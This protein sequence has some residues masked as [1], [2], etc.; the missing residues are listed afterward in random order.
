MYKE[1]LGELDRAN[2]D[3]RERT[4]QS[5]LLEPARLKRRSKGRLMEFTIVRRRVKSLWNALVVG[6]SWPCACRDYH[7]ASLRMEPRPWD[8]RGGAEGIRFQVVLTTHPTTP[9]I[10]PSWSYQV[11]DV[12][13]SESLKAI[14]AGLDTARMHER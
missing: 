8:T 10:N 4:H 3:L 6:K 7:A 1:L 12:E 9:D 11:I 5:R 2:L 13:S 14:A